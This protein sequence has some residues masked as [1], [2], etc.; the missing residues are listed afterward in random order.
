[1][2]LGSAA[3]FL[4]VMSGPNRLRL[5]G[6]TMVLS[7]EKRT[8]RHS[9]SLQQS[10]SSSYSLPPAFQS[11]T[12]TWN[13]GVKK[14]CLVHAQHLSHTSLKPETATNS[15]SPPT[16]PTELVFF[17]ASAAWAPRSALPSRVQTVSSTTTQ[18]WVKS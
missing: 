5:I 6:I 13:S 8:S 12:R 9:Y 17:P 3:F 7:S 4:G 14:H 10:E 18:T 11:H 15:D 16:G 2:I 1:M